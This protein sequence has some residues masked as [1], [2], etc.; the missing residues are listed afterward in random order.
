VLSS[1]YLEVYRYILYSNSI[2]YDS[3]SSILQPLSTYKYTVPELLATK[4]AFID[5]ETDFRDDNSNVKA[6]TSYESDFGNED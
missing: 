5:R 2:D 3:L 1:W 6:W 4:W